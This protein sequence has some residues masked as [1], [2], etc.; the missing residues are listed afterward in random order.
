MTQ[1]N[2][3]FSGGPDYPRYLANTFGDSKKPLFCP[4]PASGGQQISVRLKPERLA[5]IDVLSA[6]SGWGRNQIIDAILDTGL[7]PLF[8]FLSDQ[9]SDEIMNHVVAIVTGKSVFT[10]EQQVP[11]TIKGRG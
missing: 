3:P 1:N 6:Q 7:R 8:D 11:M 10:I 4:A 2:N 5:L 9:E